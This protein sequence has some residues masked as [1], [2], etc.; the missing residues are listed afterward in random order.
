MA[1]LAVEQRESLRSQGYVGA[2]GRPSLVPSNSPNQIAVPFL[3]TRPTASMTFE[4]PIAEMGRVVALV[5]SNA[6]QRGVTF[7][8]SAV[9]LRRRSFRSR[10]SASI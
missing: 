4:E 1:R 3:L 5:P 7:Q 8:C 9:H 10:T 6:L 2:L